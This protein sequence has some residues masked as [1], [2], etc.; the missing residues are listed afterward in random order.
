M[1]K[2]E[3]TLGDCPLEPLFKKL[4]NQGSWEARSR[5]KAEAALRSGDVTWSKIWAEKYLAMAEQHAAN[6][7]AIK[8]Q[9]D[10][11][12]QVHQCRRYL[13]ASRRCVKLGEEM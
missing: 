9:I 4:N 8:G 13:G 11:L 7:E 12:A 10:E 2:I 6:S 3:C 5:H 1:G